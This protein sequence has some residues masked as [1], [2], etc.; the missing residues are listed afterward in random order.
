VMLFCRACQVPS[1]LIIGIRCHVGNCGFIDL[2]F[3]KVAR[4]LCRCLVV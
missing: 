1:N 4:P 3:A 2:C